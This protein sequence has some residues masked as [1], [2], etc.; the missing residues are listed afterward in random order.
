MASRRRMS[1]RKDKKVFVRTARTTK[2]LNKTGM[3]AYGSI[4]L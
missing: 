4:R 1:A 3:T 2:K